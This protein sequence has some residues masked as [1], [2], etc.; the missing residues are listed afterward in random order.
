MEEHARWLVPRFYD[1]L[2]DRLAIT[3]QSFLLKTRHHTI[4]VDAC[5]GNHK[6]RERQFFNHREWPWL[7]ALAAAGACPEDIDYVL[8]TH[9][10]VDHVGWNTMLRDGSWVPTFPNAKY[11]FSHADWEYWRAESAANGLPRT[12]DYIADSV[13]PIV[14]AGRAVMTSGCH[15][16]EAGVWIEPTPGHS[17]GH[18]VVHVESGAKHAIVSGD[19]MHHPIQCRFP[20]WST[21]FC[22]DQQ[23]SRQTRRRFFETYCDTGVLIAPAHFPTPTVGFIESE[24]RAFRFRFEGE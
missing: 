8:C 19:I 14:E 2:A 7:R 5:S 6:T 9:L 10:H 1:P 15:E 13:L 24:G 11:L 3:I 22:A 21:N 16:I 4:L 17:P 20:D 23:L 18:V 12:G